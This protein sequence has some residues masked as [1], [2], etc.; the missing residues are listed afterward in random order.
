LA[1][2]EF[3]HAQLC[4]VGSFT[5]SSTSIPPIAIDTHIPPLQSSDDIMGRG[6]LY[7]IFQRPR[8]F[9]CLPVRFGVITMSLLEI[10]LSGILSVILWFE[11]SRAN[12]LTSS[13]RGSFAGGAVVET[14]L[15]L[16][17]VV[18]FI[19]AIVR[20]QTFVTAYMVGLYVHFL[21]NL[22]VA[23]YLLVLIL[24]STHIDTVILCQHA[25]KN[26]QAQGQCATLFDSVRGLYAGLASF[27]LVV[28]LYGAIVATRYVYQLRGEKRA[29]R[30]PM[31]PVSVLSDEGRL[32]PG[33]VRY[34]ETNGA[35]V[36]GSYY[37]P[38]PDKGHSRGASAYS[39]ADSEFE[40][41]T[42]LGLYD[43]H[44]AGPPSYDGALNPEDDYRDDNHENHGYEDHDRDS[45]PEP[46]PGLEPHRET[47]TVEGVRRYPSD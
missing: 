15:F 30:M 9:C 32:L 11:V 25:L 4:L 13:E 26:A 16:I 45:M 43:P 29:A 34:R 44:S 39:L 37:F 27:I 3:L 8:F 23:L 17:S 18:G 42:P 7:F 2:L 24:H 1:Q 12:A 14:F 46:P 31:R 28:E 33:F 35:T 6:I 21:I 20:K 19:G 10:L 38:P 36:Y 5:S 47:E 41:A 40:G 22:I